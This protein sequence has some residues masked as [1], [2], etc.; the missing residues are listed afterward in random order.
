MTSALYDYRDPSFSGVTHDVVAVALIA[1]LGLHSSEHIYRMVLAQLPLLGEYNIV[2]DGNEFGSLVVQPEM[3]N[4]GTAHL[5]PDKKLKPGTGFANRA[6]LK[7]N[8]SITYLIL[9]VNT[10]AHWL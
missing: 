6:F 9:A 1:R 3:R 5:K 2:E 10:T 8:S 7:Q 4:M